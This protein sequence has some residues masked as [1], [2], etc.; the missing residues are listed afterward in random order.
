MRN[1][2]KATNIPQS[3]KEAVYERDGGACVICG[4]PGAPNAHYIARSQMGLGI[5]ENIVTLCPRCHKDYDQSQKREAYRKELGK[6]LAGIYDGWNPE[7]LIY[8]K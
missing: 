4:R 6:Y 7:N 1:S 3:V 2:T 5:E 8:K